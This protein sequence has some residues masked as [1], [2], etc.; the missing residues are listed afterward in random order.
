MDACFPNVC[1]TISPCGLLIW[2]RCGIGAGRFSPGSGTAVW[3][4]MR[5]SLLLALATP[6]PVPRDTLAW[7]RDR[8]SEG[9]PVCPPTLDAWVADPRGT[10]AVVR[11]DGRH[12]ATL[13]RD[14]LTDAPIPVLLRLCGSGAAGPHGVLLALARAGMRAQRSGLFVASP[15]FGERTEQDAS[16]HHSG[17]LPPAQPQTHGKLRRRSSC[18]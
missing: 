4:A 11:H 9:S 17:V 3:V 8:V 5:P 14:M 18:L 1:D 10:A 6:L 12:R 2:S 13:A 15:L 16:R 7:L